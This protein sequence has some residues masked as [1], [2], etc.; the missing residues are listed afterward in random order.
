M[1]LG[2]VAPPFLTLPCFFS[3]SILFTNRSKLDCIFFRS[4]LLRSPISLQESFKSTR[5]FPLPLF[6]FVEL[7]Y[8]LHATLYLYNFAP[9]NPLPTPSRMDSLLQVDA[10]G[11]QEDVESSVPDSVLQNLLLKV[12]KRQIAWL[13]LLQ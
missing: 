2:H 12:R 7:K 9:L 6:F 10:R 3:P 4:D 13:L 11:S 8:F 5:G 1:S